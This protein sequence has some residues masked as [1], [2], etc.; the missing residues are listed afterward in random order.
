MQNVYF[1]RERIIVDDAS[2]AEFCSHFTE[3]NAGGGLVRNKEGRYLLIYRH[4]LWDLPKGKQEPDEDIETCAL[5]EVTEETGLHE[6]QLGPRI[7]ITHH[8]Y[9]LFGQKIIKHTYWYEMSDD[10]DEPLLPQLEE[11]ISR[12]EWVEKER[13]PEYLE[14]TYPS[15][16]E[17]FV[18]AGL[19]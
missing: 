2:F 7:C 16:V 17:V 10:R 11:D 13:L 12:A 18:N 19:L 15:I 5:R 3:V 8:C 1:E 9:Q 14:G 4:E 6:L